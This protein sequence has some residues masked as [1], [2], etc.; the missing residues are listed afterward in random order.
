MKKMV[1]NSPIQLEGGGR[2]KET[3]PKH[4]ISEKDNSC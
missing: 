2:R 3:E 1:Y 4:I